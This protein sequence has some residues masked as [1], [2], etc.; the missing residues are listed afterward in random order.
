MP[1]AIGE[2][3]LTGDGESLT[4]VDMERSRYPLRPD[5]NW[6]EDAAPFRDVRKQLDAYFAGELTVF[7][8]P[9]SLRG[10]EFQQRVWTALIKIPFG[11]TWSYAGLAQRVGNAKAS[12]AVG[13]ANGRNPIPIIVPCH[14]VIGANGTLT[15]YGGGLPRKQWLLAHEAEVLQR[16]SPGRLC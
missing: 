13:L 3:L 15:G 10:T 14:R 2:L 4:G 5:Q 11:T 12:R 1:S 7:D 16:S 6:R 8:L 9:L